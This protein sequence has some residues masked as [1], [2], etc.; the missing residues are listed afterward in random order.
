[1]AT[2]NRFNR[3]RAFALR[4]KFISIIVIVVLLVAGYFAYG[5]VTKGN[6]SPTYIS[7]AVS[8]GTITTSV[9]A[10]G[11]VSAQS[12]I[13][14]QFK[15]SGTLVYLGVKNGDNVSAGKLIAQLDTSSQQETIQSA[16]SSL[17]STQISLQKIQGQNSSTPLNKQNAQRTL[18]QDYQTGYNTISTT[19]TTLPAIM[20]G[21]KS[22][23]FGTTFNGYQQ[24]IDYYAYS[25]YTY[26][27]NSTVYGNSAKNSYGSASTAYDQNFLDYK[28]ITRSSDN[29][30]I[31]SM[32]Q[33]T[34]NTVKNISQA[35]KD[36]NNLIQFYKDT[37]TKYNIKTNAQADTDI[38]SLNGYASQVDSTVNSLLSIQN[39]IISDTQALANTD[40]DL[41]SAQLNLQQQQNSLA[42]AKSDLA[43]YFIYAPYA[44]TVGNV[45]VQK[46]DNVGSGTA[47]ATLITNQKIA[48]ISLN[49]VDV[50]KVQTGQQ[51]MLTFDAVPDLTI[52]GTVA[53]INPIGTVSQGV[54]TY[55]V[56]IAFDTQDARIKSGMSVNVEIITNVKQDV[57]TVPN[58][59]IKTQ[60]TAKYVQVLVAGAPQQ[61]I[62]AVGLSNDTNTEITSGLNEGE[63]VITQTITAR[64]SSANTTAGSS[65]LRIPG[66]G[67][68]GGFRGN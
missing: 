19:F 20:T 25:A 32:I 53:E 43:N 8:K 40:L 51:A 67:G 26:D 38:A 64:T 11:Q 28:N 2:Q 12:Q 56:K 37:L 39:S 33:E 21:L 27:N 62:V 16:E 50:A 46:L 22:I 55:T 5:A 23:L 52:A 18:D 30:T 36:A 48:T 65:T 41:Q 7:S 24:N 9:S 66:I 58:S 57:L 42:A 6:T 13:N 10:S 1:M 68:G 17:Q 61:K 34:Y 35:V 4:H 14:L 47:V 44:G 60:G 49:E 54:V 15:A 45:N 63:Q 29:G 59:A 31:N 3:F